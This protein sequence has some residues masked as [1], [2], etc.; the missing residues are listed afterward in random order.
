MTIYISASQKALPSITASFSKEEQRYIITI[1]DNYCY[2]TG[3]YPIIHTLR[4]K[5][6]AKGML[7]ARQWI[8]KNYGV[9][10]DRKVVS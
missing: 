9:S 7:R 2:I 6:L 1:R 10:N 4:D 3:T 8:S 5:R